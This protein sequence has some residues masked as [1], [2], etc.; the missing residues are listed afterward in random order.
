MKQKIIQKQ[1]QNHIKPYKL[2]P[3]FQCKFRIAIRSREDYLE[4]QE[5][6]SKKTRSAN[7][8]MNSDD[9]N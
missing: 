8:N 2:Y 3:S 4:K 6:Y 7:Q 5:R 9:G 1:C